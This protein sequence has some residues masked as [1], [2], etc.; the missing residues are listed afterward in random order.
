[1]EQL[2]EKIIAK[3]PNTVLWESGNVFDIT[4]ASTLSFI[5]TLRVYKCPNC[6][7]LILKNNEKLLKLLHE[8]V[9]GTMINCHSCKTKYFLHLEVS[10]DSKNFKQS[11]NPFNI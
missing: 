4:I 5:N 2:L 10:D 7:N 9:K 11:N 6:E 1:M 8:T 3:E